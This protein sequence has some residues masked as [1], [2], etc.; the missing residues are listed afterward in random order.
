MYEEPMLNS[1]FKSS[2]SSQ[3]VSQETLR[4]FEEL[5]EKIKN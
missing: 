3:K 2:K 4:I 5:M 1:S